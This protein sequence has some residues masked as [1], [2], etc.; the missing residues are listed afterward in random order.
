MIGLLS[1]GFEFE[2]SPYSFLART[3]EKEN[4]T[5]YHI[6]VMN[7]KL[8]K[9]LYGNH[10]LVFKNGKILMDLPVKDDEQSKLKMTIAMALRQYLDSH[11]LLPI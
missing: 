11:Q 3:K 5:E 9:L 4:F 10:I 7:G 1:I 6:T 2:G 8:E